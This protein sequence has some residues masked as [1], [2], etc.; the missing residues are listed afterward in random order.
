MTSTGANPDAEWPPADGKNY[1][2]SDEFGNLVLEIAV[3][4]MERYPTLD[5]SNAV[6]RVFVWFDAKL[7]ADSRFISADRF[8]SRFAFRAYVRQSLWNDARRTARDQRTRRELQ[9]ADEL[10]RMAAKELGPEDAATLHDEVRRLPLPH[11]MIVEWLVFE[12]AEVAFVAEALSL[13]EEEVTSLF[14]EALEILGA[15]SGG[16]RKRKTRLRKR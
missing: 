3:H 16:K 9:A 7:H 5:F 4:L 1:I 6:A 10:E 15:S 11:L 12:S 8:R 14:E 13:S 2:R